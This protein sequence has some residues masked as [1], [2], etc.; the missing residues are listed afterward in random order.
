MRIAIVNDLLMAVELLRRVV[1][2]VP[3]YQIAWIAMNGEEAVRKAHTDRPDLILMDLVMPVM[4]GVEATRRIMLQDPCPILIVTSSVATNFNKVYQAMGFGGLDAVN[5]PTLGPGNTI[6]DGEGILQRI[7]KVAFAKE[8]GSVVCDA[9]PS[10]PAASL[11]RARNLPPILALGASTGGPEAISR[12]LKVLPV[13]LRAAVLIVQHI[14]AEFAPSLAGWLECHSL[15]P[16]QVANEGTRPAPG[17]VLL[18][19]TNDHMV[20]NPDGRMCYTRDPL[21]FPY[22]PSVDVLFNSLAAHS[23]RPGVAVLLTGMGADG[24]RGL[25]RLRQAGW[26]TIAQDEKSSVVFGMPK[27]AADLGAACE[28]LS[29]D[30]LPDRVLREVAALPK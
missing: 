8:A 20:L 28:I 9:L 13:N 6:L 19:G 3:G 29:L 4:D 11:F 17:H 15:L 23:S 12:I 16:V 18:A 27:A 14:S 25:L 30:Q 26:H 5:T 2:S 7:G 24:A 22:R 1:S 21:L 10:P